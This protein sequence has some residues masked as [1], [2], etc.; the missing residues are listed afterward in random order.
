MNWGPGRRQ[1]LKDFLDGK[2]PGAGFEVTS[3]T[4]GNAVVE[5]TDGPVVLDVMDACGKPDG[6]LFHRVPTP[7]TLAAT[8]TTR[9]LQRW[10]H[11]LKYANTDATDTRAIDPQVLEFSGYVLLATTSKGAK[12][13][14]W[15][16]WHVGLISG[17]ADEL[18]DTLDTAGQQLATAAD[19]DLADLATKV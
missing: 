13:W 15:D 10:E 18:A 12:S 3:N 4:E 7:L 1:K 6:V 19:I 16:L 2:F 8:V 14:E 17:R 9:W 11:P 5:W